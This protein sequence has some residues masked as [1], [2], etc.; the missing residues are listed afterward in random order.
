[1]KKKSYEIE[2]WALSIGLKMDCTFKCVSIVRVV[3]RHEECGQQI[4][5]RWSLGGEWGGTGA[6]NLD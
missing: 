6:H 5:I 3:L 4:L 2:L 1:M